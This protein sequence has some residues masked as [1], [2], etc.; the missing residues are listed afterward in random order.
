MEEN[1]KWHAL[2][3]MNKGKLTKQADLL[4]TSALT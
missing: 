2:F 1:T 4:V 3:L